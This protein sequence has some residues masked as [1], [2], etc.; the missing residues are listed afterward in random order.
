MPHKPFS[1]LSVI[2]LS[3]LFLNAQTSNNLS[4]KYPTV[5]AYKVR[6]G[7]LMTA[8]YA[9]DGQVCEMLL[10]RRYTPDQTDA[11]ST[12]PSKLVDQLIDELAPTVERG[13]AKSRWLG[14]SF[15]A[16][17]VTH[18]GRDFENVLV[19]IDGTVSGGV[20]TVV[21]RWKNRTCAATAQPH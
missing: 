12:I 5:S 11:N 9:E 14:D 3:A 7:I 17:G 21:I 8:N 19:A 18:V 1:M 20:N 13:P 6:P 2:V 16:G 15:V 4:A 10:Q